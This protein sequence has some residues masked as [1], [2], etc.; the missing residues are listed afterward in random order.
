MGVLICMG[1]KAGVAVAGTITAHVGVSA[2]V[3][4]VMRVGGTVAVGTAL[5]VWLGNAIT[6]DVV[7]TC[8]LYAVGGVVCPWVQ[9]ATRTS[10]KLTKLNMPVLPQVVLCIWSVFA[11][12]PWL[13]SPRQLAVFAHIL[14]LGRPGVND[15]LKVVAFLPCPLV[16]FRAKAPR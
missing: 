14:H 11:L 1:D 8:G 16:T 15:F 3:G 4:N 12:C 6:C 5:R 13:T 9:A 7:A 2:A 10:S